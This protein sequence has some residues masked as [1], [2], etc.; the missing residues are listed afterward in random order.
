M[1]ND[2]I[3]LIPSSFVNGA[4]FLFSWL[5][6]VSYNTTAS[7]IVAAL[8][9]L[10]QL[11]LF[12]KFDHKSLYLCIP[13]LFYAL[14][15]G[16]LQENLL[17]H[18]YM[19]YQSAI[20]LYTIFALTLNSSF[21]F[22]NKNLPLTFIFGGVLGNIFHLKNLS[23][24]APTTYP[25]LFF[26]WGVTITL[27]FLLNRKLI[28]IYD[29]YTNPSEIKK[30]LTVFFD[31]S[32]PFCSYE[33]E[34]LKNRNQTGEVNYTCPATELEL[35]EITTA[36]TYKEAM[37]TIHAIDANNNILTGTETISALLA[38]TDLPGIAIF[39]Q[40]PGFSYIFDLG[41][42]IFTRLRKKLPIK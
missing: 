37:Q 22:L 20:L 32:C 33:M 42:A 28:Q 12:K 7:L 24:S 40:A 21:S 27:L 2:D 34:V 19:P 8:Y 29:K 39:L 31:Q 4:L 11:I 14:I 10:S 13:L 23:E 30:M 41:Y 5:F 9:F 36:F 15:L 38:R 26:S 35:R 6:I 1:K 17:S 3:R 16:A 25:I 18:F